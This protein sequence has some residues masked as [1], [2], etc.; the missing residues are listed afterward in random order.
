[1][2]S[3]SS[4]SARRW[5]ASRASAPRRRSLRIAPDSASRLLRCGQTDACRG[6]GNPVEWYLRA[7][8]R[9]VQLDPHEVPAARGP[10]SCRWHVNRGIAHPAG[11]GGRSCRL[12]HAVLSPGR[13]APPAASQLSGL[14]WSLALRTRHLLDAGVL[15]P[16]AAPAGS[17]PPG[18]AVCRPPRLVVQLLFVRYL[19]SRPVD[20]IQCVAQTLRCTCCTAKALSPGAL[21]GVGHGASERPPRPARAAVGC[22]G[23]LQLVRTALP[24]TASVACPAVCPAC[25][26]PCGG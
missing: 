24:G 17:P 16:P 25:R 5:D 9:P 11:D 10:E 20:E 6:C 18:E 15:V 22:H 2:C 21:H 13:P 3:P 26:R 1:M 12:A 4:P 23:R 8:D 7:D 14:C 19:A